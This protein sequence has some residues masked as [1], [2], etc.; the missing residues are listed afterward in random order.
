MTTA[1]ATR[2]DEEIQKDVL[3]ELK[4]DPR[5]Q[6]TEIGVAVKNGV[7][8]LTGWVD[9]FYKR[10]AAEEAAHRVRG[11]LA[12]ANDIE[13]RLPVSA[14]RTDADI[15]AAAIHALEWDAGV[16]IDNLD[17]TVSKGWVTL[18]GVVEWEYQKRDAERV[19][20]RLKGVKGVTNLLTIKPRVSPSELKQ[21]IEQALVRSAET[22]ALRITVEVEGSKVIL[23]GAVRSWAEKQE[24]E[25]AAWSAPGITSVENRITISP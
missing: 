10:W 8:T 24:A 7:V 25:R 14:E 6:S 4:W 18:R 15:A 16:S 19:V 22:D 21:K 5:V 17:V 3:N 1:T 23:R 2:T 9:S 11:V 12:V 13:V 20:R